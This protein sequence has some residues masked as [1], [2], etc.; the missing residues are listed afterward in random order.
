MS[1]SRDPKN[2]D[3]PGSLSLT[4]RDLESLPQEW[5]RRDFLAGSSL[6]MSS[7]IIGCST[8]Q[9]SGSGTDLAVTDPGRWTGQRWPAGAD[10]LSRAWILIA[11]DG[12]V[13]FT[14][15]RSEF[16]QGVLTSHTMMIA[17]ELGIQPQTVN[18]IYATDNRTLYWN[19]TF[20]M[21]ATGGSTS[22]FSA[23]IPLRHAAAGLR[24]MLQ[25]AASRMAA[26]KRIRPEDFECRDGLLSHAS[27][28]TSFT[29]AQVLPKA[30]TLDFPKTPILKEPS[31]WTL[32]GRPIARLDLRKKVDG[33]LTYGI[34]V[35]VEGLV[36]CKVIHTPQRL[37]KILTIEKESALQQPG[38]I[39]I[40]QVTNGVAVVAKSYWQALQAARKVK[41]TYGPRTHP[42]ET[43]AEYSN[44][45]KKHANKKGLI[46]NLAG[47]AAAVVTP[48]P[49]RRPFQKE[50][51]YELPFLPHSQLEPLTCVVDP[52]ETECHVWLGSQVPSVAIYFASR[53]MNLPKES[54]HFHQ[55]EMGGAFGR[56]FYHDFLYECLEVAK[57]LRRPV[58]LIWSRED[59]FSQDFFRPASYHEI[60]ANLSSKGTLGRWFHKIVGG[61]IMAYSSSD[62]FEAVLPS[63]L[64]ATTITAFGDIWSESIRAFGLDPTLVDGAREIPYIPD[65][66]T[67]ESVITDT[68]LAI[69][70][71][72]SVGFSSNCFVIESF[73]DEMALLAGVDPYAFRIR[74]LES[75][76]SRN[77]FSNWI[78]D[79]LRGAHKALGQW[80]GGL[81]V[82]LLDNPL[83]QSA[84]ADRSLATLRRLAEFAEFSKPLPT[85][86][87]RGMAVS[88]CYGSYCAQ[89]VVISKREKVLKLEKVFAVVDCGPVLNPDIARAQIEGGIIFGLS[90]ALKQEIT[91][92][93][94]SVKERN[95]HQCDL[96]RIHETPKIAIDFSPG[97]ESPSGLGELGVPGIAPALANAIAAAT[98][99]RL[100]KLPL[101]PEGFTL[102]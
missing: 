74:C 8:P 54:V 4:N 10:A 94:G 36:H 87:Y 98:G 97:A 41:I 9:K 45:L 15:D 25:A 14:L 86:H 78:Y 39:D 88:F 89:A 51:V 13:Y 30:L 34:D 90:A 59:D 31:Q 24:M 17:E 99:Q 53:V 80:T 85:G 66:M 43:S 19:S 56:R 82:N 35:Q 68:P 63:K 61:S 57:R 67:C 73:I 102:Y 33:S 60:K 28:G 7:L 40:F 50:V 44:H 5:S 1:L 29:F 77:T 81:P 42:H 84:R 16:G 70:F 12:K 23:W 62:M 96:L 11:P 55:T 72:R 49:P 65:D 64:A 101:K 22:T 3:G 38:V 26:P 20:L 91:L 21:N 2:S 47:Y 76:A 93:K 92:E 32:L 71:W 69:G 37:Q 75:G 79:R 46:S 83:I 95:F 100:R 6:L 48:P 58:K 52:R 18:V 27:T